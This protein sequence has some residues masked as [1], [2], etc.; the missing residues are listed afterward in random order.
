M[1]DTHTPGSPGWWLKRLAQRQIERGPELEKL[2]RYARGDHD[3]PEGDARVRET[4]QKFQRKA[5]SNFVG[6]VS[7]SVLERLHLTGFRAG[8]AGTD[9][10]AWRMWQANSMDADVSLAFNAALTMRESYLMVTPP[11]GTAGDYPV[12]TV[13]DPRKVIVEMDPQRRRVPRA[14]LKW[15]ADSVYGVK[16]AV[17]YLP[18]RIYSFESPMASQLDNFVSFTADQWTPTGDIPNPLGNRVPFVRLPNRQGIDGECLA[19]A[20]DVLDIQDRINSEILDRLV[21]SKMQAYR[22]RWITGASFEDEE[23]NPT[24]PF[25]PGADLV[26]AVEDETAKFGDFTQ[27]DLRP[28]L[29]AVRDDVRDMAAISRTPPH[30]LL[31][32]F[33]NVGGDGFSISETGLVAKTKDRMAH[34]GEAIEDAIRLGYAYLGDTERASALDLEVIWADPQYRSMAEMADAATKLSAAGVPWRSLMAKVMGFTPAEIDRMAAERASD[35]LLMQAFAQSQSP[36]QREVEAPE[37][38]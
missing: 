30:Y 2:H 15:W 22:Q 5:R 23:G 37:I 38:E 9:D 13:E 35:N 7:S 10:D 25:K 1:I 12:I 6:L 11:D 32:E 29:A 19:E 31:G 18:T 20:E 33:T 34:F 16:R 8:N 4:Y 28:I 3:L 21:I 36:A 26:W 24:E 17:L 27:A 14:A